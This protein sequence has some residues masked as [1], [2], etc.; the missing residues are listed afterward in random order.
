MEILTL[1]PL[2]PDGVRATLEFVFSVHP[3][4]TGK[5]SEASVP[6][7]KGANITH[8]A[9]EMASRLLS[10]TPSSVTP[11]TWYAGVAPQLMQLLDGSEGPEL[12]KTASYII[13]FGI[14]GRKASGAPGMMSG[15]HLRNL[16]ALTPSKALL[17]GGIWPSHCYPKLDRLLTL[18]STEWQMSIQLPSLI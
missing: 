9:L 8:E 12:L 14:L 1:A 10:I 7:K 16:A 6:Q 5:V 2:R 13:G 15:I 17:A 3:S 4:S 11:D 18:P